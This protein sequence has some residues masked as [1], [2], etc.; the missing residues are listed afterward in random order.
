MLCN[1]VVKR[2]RDYWRLRCV[3]RYFCDFDM[4]VYKMS[5]LQL[6]IIG[7]LALWVALV[8]LLVKVLSI[9][10]SPPDDDARLESV[11]AKLSEERP[12]VRAGVEK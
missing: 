11:R 9:N 12:H 2:C 6:S 8:A 3:G 7:G 5:N 1:S 4:G 10:K